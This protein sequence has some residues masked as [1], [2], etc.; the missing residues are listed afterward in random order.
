MANLITLQVSITVD[1]DEMAL[2]GKLT[3]AGE[4]KAARVVAKIDHLLDQAG[5]DLGAVG[6]TYT[7]Q[8]QQVLAE[9]GI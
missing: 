5:Q 6:N 7:K 2:A 9:E 1:L 3:D 8:I 4:D